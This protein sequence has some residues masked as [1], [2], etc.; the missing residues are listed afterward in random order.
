M[1][2]LRSAFRALRR[3]RSGR[4]ADRVAQQQKADQEPMAQEATLSFLKTRSVLYVFRRRIRRL[5][6]AELWETG[7]VIGLGRR[8]ERPE[9]VGI[10]L[11]ESALT[12]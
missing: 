8:L 2:R 3:V 9:G 7:M 6:E 5:G 12:H 1:D 11:L 10:F 4:P